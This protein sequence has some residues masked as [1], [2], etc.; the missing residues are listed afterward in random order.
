[1]TLSPSTTVIATWNRCPL[2]RATTPPTTMRST[3]LR[4]AA[5]GARIGDGRY[6]LLRRLGK[7]AF[8]TAYE[9]LD[10]DEDDIVAVKLLKPGVRPDDVLREARLHRRLSDHP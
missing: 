8:G 5:V 3:L 7:G 10:H 4:M 2:C 1:M 6:E 9:A